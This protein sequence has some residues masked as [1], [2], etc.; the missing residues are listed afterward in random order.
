MND[1][2]LL[3]NYDLDDDELNNLFVPLISSTR[4]VSSNDTHHIE[5]V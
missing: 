2:E 1:G 4:F 3:N 5:A